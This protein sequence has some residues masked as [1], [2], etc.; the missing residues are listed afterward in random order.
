[1]GDKLRA[2]LGIA[3]KWTQEEIENYAEFRNKSMGPEYSIKKIHVNEPW[4]RVR[5][6]DQKLN[7]GDGIK[8]NRILNV[9]ESAG[10]P[11]ALIFLE[12]MNIKKYY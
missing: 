1:M 7:V 2:R 9:A 12:E 10:K 4:E 5:Y 3:S 8:E 11:D 6:L